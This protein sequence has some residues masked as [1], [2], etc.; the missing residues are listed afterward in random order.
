VIQLPPPP[1]FEGPPPLPIAPP[2]PPPVPART[3]AAGDPPHAGAIA[4]ATS[5]QIARVALHDRLP[6]DE[7]DDPH[8]IAGEAVAALDPMSVYLSCRHRL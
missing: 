5:A 4:S 6:G 1:G 3:P 7:C 8:D 2:L